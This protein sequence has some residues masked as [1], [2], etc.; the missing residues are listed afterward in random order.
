[1]PLARSFRALRQKLQQA[2]ADIASTEALIARLEA[3]MSLPEIYSN[4]AESARVAHEHR[5]AQ[6]R[7]DALYEEWEALS[8]AVGME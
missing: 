5:D 8:E 1:M 6:A 3:D 4:P 7:L 2:E